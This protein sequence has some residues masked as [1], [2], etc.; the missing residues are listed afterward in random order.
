[1]NRF[2]NIKVRTKMVS[3]FSVVIVLLAILVT[4]A[5]TELASTSESYEYVI[6]SPLEAEMLLR[7]T[8]I[9]IGDLRRSVMTMALFAHA[10][11]PGMVERYYKSALEEYDAG[12]KTVE[13]YE[14][15]LIKDPFLSPAELETE[16]K[17][18]EALKNYFSIYKTDVCDTVYRDAIAGNPEAVVEHVISGVVVGTELSELIYDLTV[19]ADDLSR[20]MI[21]D[22]KVEA[23]RAVMILLMIA[24]AAAVFSVLAAV[25]ISGLISKPLYVLSAFLNKA[26]TT[27]DIRILPEDLKTINEYSVY[28]DETG[29]CIAGAASFIRHVTNIAEELESVAGG[30]L[31]GDV[32][33]LSDAD[34]M[35]N[36]LKNMIESL[37]RMFAEINASTVQV[38]IGSK[39]IADG[40][41]SLAQG[42][43]EQASSVEQLSASISEIA[44]KTK[45]NADMAGKAAS[46]AGVI[47]NNAEKGN[48]QMDEMMSAVKDINQASQ[49]ISKV[50]KVID[51]I[52]FQTNILALNAAVEAA[53]A[54]QHGKGFAV[55][56]EEVRNLAAKSAEAA[57]ETGELI[58]NSMEKAEL[59]STIAGET[60]GSLDEIVN[61]INESSRIVE[62]IAR[63]SKEQSA[64]TEQINQGI[65]QVAQVIQQNS[66]TA[67]ESA[68]ASEEM[69]GQAAMLEDLISNFKMKDS[70]SAHRKVLPPAEPSQKRPG[71]P[72]RSDVR[73]TGEGPANLGKY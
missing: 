53:R 20:S 47:K 24:A 34:T 62:L 29:R 32:K 23:D 9:N 6:E 55:V 39:Q 30:N 38:S 71:L 27:G 2:K 25:Y 45:E 31:T 35:G 73:P 51:D 49:N 11:D 19:S 59:G 72:Q 67:E 21:A 28:R 7:M 15:L 60:A 37:N 42:A 56:A 52:A 17:Y 14:D 12:I 44:Q 70:A 61:G 18:S 22:T 46:L 40:S 3:G 13:I 43:T 48:L 36:S 54:G 10:D 1:M 65:D 4:L 63:S 50:I 16:L 68:A 58:A 26:G 64:A 8:D 66:A 69:S 41:Q 33:L 57:K 5:A